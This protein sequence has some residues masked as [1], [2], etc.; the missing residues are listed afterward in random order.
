MS[1]GFV[2]TVYKVVYGEEGAVVF[3]VYTSLSA[4]ITTPEKLERYMLAAHAA[5]LGA[6]VH[7]N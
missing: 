3:R 6:E 1:G 2:N 5:G 4:S 7:N